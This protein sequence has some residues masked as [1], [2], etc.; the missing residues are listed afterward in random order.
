MFPCAA[1][2]GQGWGAGSVTAWLPG[3]PGIVLPPG[4]RSSG[5]AFR[6]RAAGERLPH[7]H[8]ELNPRR[9]WVP[10][11]HGVSGGCCSLQPDPPCL[12]RVRCWGEGTTCLCRCPGW[13]VLGCQALAIWPQPGAP[14]GYRS[15]AELPVGSGITAHLQP[16]PSPIRSPGSPQAA[17]DFSP[18]ATIRASSFEGRV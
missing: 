13:S 1:R 5:P 8:S 15:H 14:L 2:C 4:L 16:R 12:A 7:V 6:E 9:T 18:S 11:V 17:P 10:A 3:I